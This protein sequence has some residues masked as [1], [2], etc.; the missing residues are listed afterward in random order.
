M[1]KALESVPKVFSAN[2]VR[3]Y[4]PNGGGRVGKLLE[5]VPTDERERE[6]DSIGVEE[7]NILGMSKLLFELQAERGIRTA[8]TMP[9]YT[10][11]L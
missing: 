5:S 8:G 9:G 6:S 10:S 4:G 2:C 1:C 11:T 7:V 3:I